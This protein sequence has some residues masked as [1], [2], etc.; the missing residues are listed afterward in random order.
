MLP[1]NA[2][3]EV[4]KDLSR[5]NLERLQEIYS[6][7]IIF[8]DPAHEIRG[9]TSLQNYFRKLYE[10]I[11]SIAFDFHHQ[12]Q[13]GSDAYVQWEMTFRHPRIARGKPVMV[14]GISFL[15]FDESG[16]VHRHR[17]YFDLGTMLYEH[18][19]LLGAL[20]KKIKKGL[21]S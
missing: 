6:R 14:P 8:S 19:P 9:L 20:I 21:G 2:F 1:L 4:Y 16:K 12:Q 15:K 5:N 17:D 7:D 18:V 10:H 11:E 13:V 3:T